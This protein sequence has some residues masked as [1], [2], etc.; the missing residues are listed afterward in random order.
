MTMT[1]QEMCITHPSLSSPALPQ[2]WML[3]QRSTRMIRFLR[4]ATPQNTVSRVAARNKQHA[5]KGDRYTCR[6]F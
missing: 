5:H 1:D 2:R 6:P 4:I 3:G